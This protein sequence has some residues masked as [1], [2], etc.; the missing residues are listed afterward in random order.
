MLDLIDIE[1]FLLFCFNFLLH[2][3]SL[4]DMSRDI[5]IEDKLDASVLNINTT[6]VISGW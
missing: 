6:I 5:V 3:L 2:Y 4:F 1:S